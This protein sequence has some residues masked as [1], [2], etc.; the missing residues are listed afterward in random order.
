MCCAPRERRAKT[1]APISKIDSFLTPQRIEVW[2][3]FVSPTLW[4]AVRLPAMSND[5]SFPHERE[6]MRDNGNLTRYEKIP[7]ETSQG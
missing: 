7:D 5:F 3:V 4:L 1:G 6:R 2:R